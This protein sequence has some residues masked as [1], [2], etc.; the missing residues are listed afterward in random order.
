MFDVPLEPY[1]VRAPVFFILRSLAE[2]RN[3]LDCAVGVLLIELLL[4]SR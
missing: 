1:L 2:V 4:L 3:L